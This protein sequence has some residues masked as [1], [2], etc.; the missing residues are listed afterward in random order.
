MILKCCKVQ[1][2]NIQGFELSSL[3]SWLKC[4]E[5]RLLLILHSMDASHLSFLPTKNFRWVFRYYYG[6][7]ANTVVSMVGKPVDMFFDRSNS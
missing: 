6:V 4:V 1:K 7:N 2:T 3:V 5:S